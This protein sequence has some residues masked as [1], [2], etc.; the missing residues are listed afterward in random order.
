MNGLQRNAGTWA[1]NGGEN[2]TSARRI[3]C[4]QLI[5]DLF[6]QSR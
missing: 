5:P 3:A 1:D 2:K 4:P 6:Q